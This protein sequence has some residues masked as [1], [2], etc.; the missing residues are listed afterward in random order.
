MTFAAQAA[1]TLMLWDP[2][3]GSQQDAQTTHGREAS[4]ITPTRSEVPVMS[5]DF[6]GE[7]DVFHLWT[8]PHIVDNHVS[9]P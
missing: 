4:A 6:P 7:Q 3:G 1:E 2:G 5:R 8:L 9:F